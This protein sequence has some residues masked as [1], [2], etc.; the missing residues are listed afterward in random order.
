[1]VCLKADVAPRS[2]QAGSVNPPLETEGFLFSE[3][4]ISLMTT[5]L[6]RPS[7]VEER[8][9]GFVPDCCPRHLSNAAKQ[10]INMRSVIQT[11]PSYELSIDIA[12]T[13][14]GHS[15]KFISFVPTARR[16]ED[17]VRYQVL[18]S[19]AELKALR[20]VIEMELAN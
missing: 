4:S 8:L 9:R 13:D 17:Q 19:T 6:A 16:P 11:N 14:H 3:P 18:L 5:G 10:E 20:D 7:L 1:V 12:L 15:L 2:N